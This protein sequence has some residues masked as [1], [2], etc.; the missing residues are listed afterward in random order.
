MFGVLLAA[1]LNK[2]GVAQAAPERPGPLM[3]HN[4]PLQVATLVETAFADV[5]LV[6]LERVVHQAV[7]SKRVVVR[8]LLAAVP[9]DQLAF[10]VLRPLAFLLRFGL[11]WRMCRRG[12]RWYRLQRVRRRLPLLNRLGYLG[13][14]TI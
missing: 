5:A 6:R 7:L 13:G 3:D 2:L 9:A 8:E 12:C 11:W 4:V 14:K 10:G 1:N